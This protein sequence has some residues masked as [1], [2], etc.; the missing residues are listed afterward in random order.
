MRAFADHRRKSSFR[1]ADF[2]RLMTMLLMLGVLWM[3]IMR[4]PAI[5]GS[6][7]PVGASDPDG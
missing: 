2:T 5:Q 6:G 3:M 7:A 4:A 1:V